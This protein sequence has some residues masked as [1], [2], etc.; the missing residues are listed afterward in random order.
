[1]W[2]A[3]VELGDLAGGQ[4]EVVFAEQQAHPP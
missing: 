4:D 1:V 2:D 3:G